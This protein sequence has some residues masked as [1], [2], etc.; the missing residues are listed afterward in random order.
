MPERPNEDQTTRHSLSDVWS[1]IGKQSDDIATVRTSVAALD[2]RVNHG[3]SAIGQQ[4]N[5]L[6]DRSNVKPNIAGWLS[7]A[8]SMALVMGAIGFAN[9]KPVDD[10]TLKNETRVEELLKDYWEHAGYSR[11][12][13]ENFGHRLQRLEADS[14]S[15]HK[16]NG[17]GVSPC[18]ALQR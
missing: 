2:A 9:L 10:R 15:F 8:I 11:G 16:R 18:E 7:L 14:D 1:A 3:L 12:V 17:K 13:I 6:I 4:L 5:S